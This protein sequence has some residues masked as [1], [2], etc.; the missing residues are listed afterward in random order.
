MSHTA[1]E[2]AADW[3]E[4]LET[5]VT[6]DD[7]PVDNIPSAKQQ[8]LLVVALYDSWTPPPSEEET[9]AKR[10]FL[11]IA[12]VGLFSSPYNPP[13]VPDMMLSLDVEVPLDWEKKEHR[14]YF[15]WLHEKAPD[16]AVEIV[17]NKVGKELDEKL[18][19]YAKLDVT[20]Y[21]VYDP[22]R[23]LSHDVLRVYERGFGKRYRRRDD[24]QLPDVGL[25]L[26]LWEGD[27]EDIPGPWLRWCE[28]NGNLLLTGAERAA[29][30]EERATHAE[31]ENARLREEVARLRVQLRS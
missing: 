20:Y 29:Q 22:Q 6:E 24:F 28:A 5:L 14:S 19:R 23:L 30:A 27:Y 9:E 1:T 12:N 16:V 25:S 11:A 26:T 3:N 10:K 18:R 8:Q 4:L 17:S 21:V 13:L 7:E 31:A 15:I 2:T